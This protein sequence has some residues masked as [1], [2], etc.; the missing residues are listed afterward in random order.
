MVEVKVV[1]D[2]KNELEL[3]INS[4]TIA[5]ILRVYLNKDESVEFAAWR[6]EHPTKPLILKIETKGKSPRKAIEDA[7]EKIQKESDKLASE[8]KKLQ[9]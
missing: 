5:E 6:R 9:L 7:I 3:E 4:L 8:V 1:K 2:E